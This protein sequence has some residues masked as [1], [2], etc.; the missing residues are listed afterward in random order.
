MEIL[1]G[2]I[3]IFVSHAGHDEHAVYIEQLQHTRVSQEGAV[4]IF[5]EKAILA[6]QSYKK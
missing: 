6:A 5:T 4:F 3:F 1:D 2:D